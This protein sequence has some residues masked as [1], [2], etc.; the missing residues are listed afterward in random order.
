M[1]GHQQRPLRHT[2]NLS[3]QTD[4]PKGIKLLIK[5]FGLVDTIGVPRMIGTN[6][7]GP[8]PEDKAFLAMRF[9]QV[10]E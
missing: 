9:H 6:P 4:G 8:A 7:K 10:T 2:K 1:T 5:L 3:C